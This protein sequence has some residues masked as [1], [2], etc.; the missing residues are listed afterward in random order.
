M[1]SFLFDSLKE[2]SKEKIFKFKVAKMMTFKFF[3][4]FVTWKMENVERI[5]P[6]FPKIFQFL[7]LAIS[8]N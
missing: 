4:F 6:N 1:V 2:I 5:F 8:S 3:S 7:A